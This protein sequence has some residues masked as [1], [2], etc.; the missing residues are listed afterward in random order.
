[1]AAPPKPKAVESSATPVPVATISF[2]EDLKKTL[3]LRENLKKA[4]HFEVLGVDKKAEGG[5][6]KAA[7]FKL[8]RSFHPD[9][10]NKDAPPELARA[11]ADVFAMVGEANRILSDAKLRKE[12]ELELEAGTSEKIDLQAILKGEEC[13]RKGVIN[14]KARKW[15]EALK[16]LDE[17]IA[18]NADE[19]EFYAWRGYARF[20]TI[21]DKKEAS[22]ASVPEIDKCLAKNPRVAAAYYFKGFIA[23]SLGDMNAAKNNF[24]KCVELDANHI[25]AQRELRMMK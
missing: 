12:Y 21:A 5:V 15:P 14:V 2:E 6:I 10:V 17:A 23:K 3:A 24:K 11:K 16:L 8:A 13:F 4:N 25:D 20:F 18:A 19:P 1:M 7:Y 9:M 22:A